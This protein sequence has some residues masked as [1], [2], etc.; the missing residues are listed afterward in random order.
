MKS[1][2]NI[3]FIALNISGAETVQFAADKLKGVLTSY[4]RCDFRLCGS[5]SQVSSSLSDAFSNS[6]L[7]VVGLEPSVYC[8]SKLAILRAM[9]VKTQ[10]NEQL[11]TLIGD[12]KDMTAYQLSMHCAMPVNAEIFPTEDGLYSGFA[13]QS[14]KQ[15]FVML[16]LDKLRL[17]PVTEKG[18]KPMLEKYAPEQQER[19]AAPDSK[20]AEKAGKMLREKDM[21]VY[22]AGTPSCE[23]V[24]DLCSEE[25]ENG[26]FVFTSYT[27]QRGDEA[28]RSYIADLARYAIPQGESALGA[29]VSNVFTGASQE[30][31]EQKYNVYVAVADTAA[32]RV[33]R[34]VSQTGETP[35]ELI[36]AAIEMLMEMI[37]DKC[38]E[39]SEPAAAAESFS[40]EPI[41]ELEEP[42]PEEKT[43]KKYRGIR[44]AVYVLVAMI[45]AAAVLVGFFG[46]DSANENRETAAAA[47][48]AAAGGAVADSG[49]FPF[50]NSENSALGPFV[51]FEEETN[52]NNTEIN[53]T[54]PTTIILN[55]TE[56]SENIEPS[57]TEKATTAAKPTTEKTT[58]PTT[59]KKV[60]TTAKPATTIPKTTLAAV[61]TAVTT[62]A[63]KITQKPTEKN[64]TTAEA[65]VTRPET[66]YKGTF[67]FTV[68]GYGHGV[69]MS[70]EGALAMARAGKT[71]NEILLHYFPGTT[72]VEADS[73]MPET[74]KYGAAEYG[75]LEYLCCTVAAEIGTG[76]NASNKEAFKAQAVVAYTYAKRY[77]FTLSASA[78]AFK[79][80]YAF[81]GTLLEQAV[82]EIMG[83]YVSYGG[84][85]AMTTY[86]AMSAGKT[87]KA[88][89]VWSGGPYPYLEQVVDSS[90]DKNCAKYKTTYEISADEFSALMEKN[91]GVELDGN[92][93]GWIK[94]IEHDGAVS[95]DIGY[96]AKMTVGSKTLSGANFRATAMG[97]RIRSHCFTVSYKAD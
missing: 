48:A 22:F 47:F 63:V 42:T 83:N 54:E 20:L 52:E 44:T 27:A 40:A 5:M 21:K 53:I 33:L 14:G 31:G 32:S 60:T 1:Q 25:I 95:S 71:C 4:G 97:Y 70:Q 67:T 69:G 68:Y 41:E 38:A 39:L 12:A 19:S 24:K 87:T 18:L 59:T 82:K 13:L 90:Y 9:H 65:T 66:K 76:C 57:T 50:L 3:S 8:K 75:M 51:E 7:V 28:P 62:T 86:F 80:G 56:A 73:A 30:T 23:M 92:P 49:S 29:A 36:T 89:S 93:A 11:K 34:F 81:E 85:P 84:Q 79:K 2:M 88:S 26:T 15:H 77:G 35:E 16:T 74:V 45:L 43:K 96:V 91:I 10:L 78:H 94:I 61:T 37:C 58:K 72:I 55:T 17:D 46:F 6:D 64:T